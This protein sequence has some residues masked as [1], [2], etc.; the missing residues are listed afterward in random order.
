MSSEVMIDP[1]AAVQQVL[2]RPAMLSLAYQPIVD[3][4]R[5][6]VAGYEVLARLPG[7][8]GPAWWFD[9]AHAQGVG[10]E[11]ELMVLERVIAQLRHAPGSRFLSVN[12][13]PEA[14]A[15]PRALSIVESAGERTS[16]LVLELTEHVPFADVDAL[17]ATL[18][19]LRALG[20]LVAID[21]AG[22]DYAGLSQLA[23]LRPDIVKIHST[24]VS[25][26]ASDPAKLALAEVLGQY[27]GRL[28]AWIVAT[29][30]E[31]TDDLVAL[32]EAGIPLAQGYLLGHP[33]VVMTDLEPGPHELVLDAI[34]RTTRSEDMSTLIQPYADDDERTPPPQVVVTGDNMPVAVVVT[35]GEPTVRTVPVSLR[36]NLSMAVT[37][38]ARRAMARPLETRF[39][40]VVVVDTAGSLVGVFT[41]DELML[42]LASITEA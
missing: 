39:D 33:G 9:M 41:V 5:G 23:D 40:P 20:V 14:L 37:E 29:G 2:A 16:R 24:L 27:A 19:P 4:S 30:L 38:V 25:G 18:A 21:D 1:A 31:E 3:M 17:I 15:H 11:L 42:H 32:V 13:S 35:G 12:M 36:V 22:A 7:P 10:T 8:T 28:D 6:E 26:A 34:A